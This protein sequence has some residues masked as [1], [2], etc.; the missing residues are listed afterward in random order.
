M[1]CT[2]EKLAINELWELHNKS[3]L[4]LN[5][6]GWRTIAKVSDAD[7]AKLIEARKIEGELNRRA[8]E[9]NSNL[10]RKI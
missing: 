2:L 9:R 4:W 8:R 6:N 7:I 1:S 3:K 5:E 10:E